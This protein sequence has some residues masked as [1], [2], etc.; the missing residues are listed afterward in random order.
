M[1]GKSL[2]T[3]L[4]LVL[5]S[6][7]AAHA[8]G[9]YGCSGPVG[10]ITHRNYDSCSSVPF[11]SPANDTRLNLELLLIDSGKLVNVP[12]KLAQQ[13]PG[14]EDHVQL[15]VPFNMEDWQVREPGES[16]KASDDPNGTEDSNDYAQGEGSR[17]RNSDDGLAAFE[18]ALKAAKKLPSDEVA[19]LDTARKT[20][21]AICNP[22]QIISWKEPAGIHSALGKQFAS[23]IAGASAFYMGGFAEALNDFSA[24]EKSP[25]PWLRET[26]FYM[27][28]RTQLNQAQ[29]QAFGEWG[30]LQMDKVDKNAL[31]AAETAFDIYLQKY[32][33]GQYAASA[34]GLLRRVYWLGGDQTRLAAAY[35][36]ALESGTPDSLNVTV[37][38]L[39]EELDTKLLAS[40]KADQIKSP[41]LLA[42]VDLMRM[43]SQGD[44]AGGTGNSNDLSLAELEAQ[45]NLFAK[46]PA[47]YNYLLAAFYLYVDIKPEQALAL[48]PSTPGGNLNYFA[49]SQQTLRVLA[50]EASHRFDDARKLV[51]QLFP[52]SSMLLQH[53]QLELELAMIEERTGRVDRVFAPESPVTDKAIRTI[54]VENV[55][56]PDLLRQRIKD[57]KEN[58]EVRDAAL[59]TLLFKELTG[60]RYQAFLSDLAFVPQHP[61]KFLEPFVQPANKG[62]SGYQCPALRETAATLQKNPEDAKSLNCLGELVRVYGVHYDQEAAPAKTDLGGSPSPF[63]GSPFSRMDAYLKVIGND[64]A[65]SD[66][67]AYAL[68]RAIRCFAPSGYN[69]CGGQDVPKSTRKQWFH[70]LKTAYPDS[71]WA[72]SLKYYW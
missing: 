36:K 61:S 49:F 60:K 9:D 7:L 13:Y 50:L 35:E 43:R 56:G 72:Q 16:A 25:D 1:L 63:P 66:A 45:K 19:I 17:C 71:L 48:L 65:E 18:E 55:A 59:Y 34:Q 46:K 22:T 64:H 47:L 39:I 15:L 2:C 26:S 4:V 44:Q 57:S 70:T 27:V 20:M 29:Q 54:L 41:Q 5:L 14:F 30:D 40:V 3:A 21:P 8:S 28:G 38:E 24:L 68:Y 32:P 67:R 69:D 53:E 11:L 23:Y 10:N 6:P 31:K 33:D 42:I 37:L 62:A 58:P 52:V 12:N 51:L